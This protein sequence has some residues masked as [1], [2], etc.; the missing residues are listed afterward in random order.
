MQIMALE[1]A[2]S[3][4]EIFGVMKQGKDALQSSVKEADV[5]N[6]EE[7]MADLNEQMDMVDQ[8][9]DA[10]SNP[11]GPQ[12][13]EDELNAEFENLESEVMDEEMLAA[14]DLPSKQI[15]TPSSAEK[16]VVNAPK[17]PTT[18]KKTETAEEKEA[19]EMADLD[20]LMA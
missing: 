9:G 2:A 7:V 15:K 4:K 17:V 10:I 12:M 16:D 6:V 13:D 20:N 11:L 8:L 18:I 3:H 14:P 5:E 1:N 19:R